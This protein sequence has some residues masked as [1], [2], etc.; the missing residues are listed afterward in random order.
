MKLTPTEFAEGRAIK[1]GLS[2]A[3]ARILPMLACGWATN[4]IAARL[5]VSEKTVSTHRTRILEKLRLMNNAE[6]TVYALRNEI[7]Q[8]VDVVLVNRPI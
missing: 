8:V 7:I 6:L 5:N 2:L 4:T 3:Q 1:L